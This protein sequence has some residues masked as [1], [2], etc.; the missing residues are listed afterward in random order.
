MIVKIFH[1]CASNGVH[2]QDADIASDATCRL[3]QPH[4][5]NS[6]PFPTNNVRKPM[7]LCAF[8]FGSKDNNSTEIRMPKWM[9]MIQEMANWMRFSFKTKIRREI[10]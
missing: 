2:I 1:K 10:G 8:E 7:S 3:E 9:R 5:C 6:K 4:N